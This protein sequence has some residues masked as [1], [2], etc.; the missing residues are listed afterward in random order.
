MFLFYVTNK[1]DLIDLI[2]TDR[3]RNRKALSRKC[4]FLGCLSIWGF[5]WGLAWTRISVQAECTLAFFFLLPPLL[6][7]FRQPIT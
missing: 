6:L 7:L 5:P 4:A 1:F 2:W 3:R